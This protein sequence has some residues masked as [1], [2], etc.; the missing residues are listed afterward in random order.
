MF[1]VF[2]YLFLHVELFQCWR[3]AS[4]QHSH[5]ANTPNKN[6]WPGFNNR[7]SDVNHYWAKSCDC[8]MLEIRFKWIKGWITIKQLLFGFYERAELRLSRWSFFFISLT[9]LSLSGAGAAAL[10]YVSV[11]HR[12]CFVERADSFVFQWH[13]VWWKVFDKQSMAADNTPQIWPNEPAALTVLNSETGS[14]S[15]N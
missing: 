4:V 14:S 1:V 9:C 12:L 10:C 11:N 8:S 13:E 3:A 7:N 2:S 15:K 6:S 5:T